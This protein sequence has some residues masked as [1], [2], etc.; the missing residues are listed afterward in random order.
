MGIINE[1]KI[2]APVVEVNTAELES[3]LQILTN[4]VHTNYINTDGSIG[5]QS[6]LNMDENK[7]MNISTEYPPSDQ[8][9]AVSWSQVLKFVRIATR[10]LFEKAGGKI[11]G[12]VNMD[13]NKILN[14]PTDYPPSD[15]AQAL[16]WS[17]IA[18]FLRRS[19]INLA[20]KTG[21]T[22][23]GDIN[24]GGNKILNMSTS[25][26]PSS[27][28]QAVSWTQALTLVTDAKGTLIKKAGDTFTGNINMSGN[29]ITN[30]SNPDD[31]GDVVNKRTMDLNLDNS[32]VLGTKALI[33]APIGVPN[34]DNLVFIIVPILSLLNLNESQRIEEVTDPINNLHFKQNNNLKRPTFKFDSVIK[35]HYLEFNGTNNNLVLQNYQIDRLGGQNAYTTT[36]FLLV[37]TYNK[38]TQSQFRWGGSDIRFNAHIP[39]VNGILYFDYGDYNNNRLEVPNQ[40]NLTGNLELWTMRIS[41]H[42]KELFRGTNSM[43][44]IYSQSRSGGGLPKDL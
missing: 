5:M 3:R 29:K 36:L 19:T 11:T 12:D 34:L 31:D 10:K 42:K 6:N 32:I 28:N 40:Q 21:E 27:N 35:H 26:P 14:L 2:A 30:V 23:S 25:Y 38:T 33:G 7:I 22:F 44:P 18:Q 41:E 1:I 9:Q 17:Q 24:M 39:H 37:K 43:T 16:S 4:E 15:Q 8:A 13:G 20:N